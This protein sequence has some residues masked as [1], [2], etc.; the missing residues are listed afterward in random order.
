VIDLRLGDCLN[1]MGSLQGGSID[2][3]F[4]DLP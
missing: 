1:E 4:A 3:V 2:L